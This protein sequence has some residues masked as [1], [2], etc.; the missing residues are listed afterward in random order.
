MID[1]RVLREM[2]RNA[3]VA[4]LQITAAII[5]MAFVVKSVIY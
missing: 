3:F 5:V 2:Q 1:E 4:A